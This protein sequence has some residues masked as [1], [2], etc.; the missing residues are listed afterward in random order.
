MVGGRVEKGHHQ[1]SR[2]EGDGKGREGRK[3]S[4]KRRKHGEKTVAVDALRATRNKA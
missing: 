2:Q 4:V 1:A 3:E